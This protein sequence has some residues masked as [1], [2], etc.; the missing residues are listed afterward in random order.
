MASPP[1]ADTLRDM[2]ALAQAGNWQRAAELADEALRHGAAHP[3]LYNTRAIW[4]EKQD[5]HQDALEDYLRALP[6]APGHA[7]LLS[8][9]GLCLVR[10]NRAGDALG[11]LAQAIAQA[12][13]RPG[14]YF[15]KGWAH[16]AL[17]DKDDARRAYQHALERD[18]NH[19]QA[20][21]ALAMMDAR[22]GKAASAR[23][24]AER[25]FAS[26]PDDEWSI[27]AMASSE[28]ADGAFAAA[29]G[30]LRTL[31]GDASRSRQ[32]RA[33]AQA[34][35]GAALEGL[36]RPNEAFTAFAAKGAILHDLH[37][38]R[39]ADAP[40][41]IDRLK[42]L[43]N[44]METM[45]AQR[46][47]RTPL[48]PDSETPRGHVFLLG[49]IRSG[50]TLLERVL[51]SDPAVVHVEERD[52]LGDTRPEF[53]SDPEA[54]E[55]LADAPALILENAR[56]AYWQRVRGFGVAPEGRIVIDKQPLSTVDL[57][58]IWRLFPD[59]K[60]LFALRDPRDV[61]LS[62]F[63]RYFEVN[64]TTFELLRLEDTARYYAEVMRW[65]QLCRDTLGLDLHMHRYEDMVSGFE[66]SAR[67]VCDFLGI[68]WSEA[69][70]DFSAGAR[71]ETIRSPSAAQVRRPLYRE[72]VGQWRGYAKE[73]APALPILQ[74]WIARFGYPQ[75]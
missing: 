14:P 33:R 2:A 43:A 63:R 23:Q 11:Y 61:V 28:I 68:A 67:A 70:R 3:S 12:P 29:E 36:G 69:M 38:P 22:D 57:P 52:T 27:L 26:A 13:Q 17:D 31:L 42:A 37:A 65:G 62:V 66:A 47:T 32:T 55:R 45:D 51:L 49:F 35:L 64:A 54:L 73:M 18:P 8:A 74:P 15:Y 60:I 16:E 75:D 53:L 19:A 72:G 71:Q 4:A 21:A 6:F 39:L 58:L 24:R 48:A 30:R 41:A 5:R 44:R 20:L 10:V 56:A 50:T 25:A 34:S 9:I 59:A 40:R 1:L 46:W 7:L